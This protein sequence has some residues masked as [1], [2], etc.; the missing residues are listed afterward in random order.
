MWRFDSAE[1]G[2][3]GDVEA[4]IAEARSNGIV[5]E[6]EYRQQR[7]IPAFME[8]RSVVVDPTG[9]QITMWSATQVPHILRFAL[10]ATTGV[11]ESK[12]RVIAPDV[13]GGFGGK[14]QQTPEE[15]IAF[16]VARRLGKPVKFTETRSE[17]LLTAHHGRDQWQRLTLAATKDGTV[18][19]LKVDLLADLGAY[20]AIVGGGV[21]VLGA[22]MFNAIYKFPAYQFQTTNVLTNKTWTDAYRGA[23]RPEATFA[24]ERL[25]DE[26]RGRG[27]RGPAGDP[28]EELDHPRGVPVHHGR[29]PGVRLRE[30]RGRHGARQGDVRLRRA[31]R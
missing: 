13:G 22:F 20:V 14:L 23:G 28:G 31:A 24:I 21:P 16:A 5:I 19:G 17:S 18:T 8:P 3:G 29:R 12:I 9:E 27:R 7:L 2:T 10:A 11:P 15:M 30:L 26:S 6:R 25:M 4:A 1:A